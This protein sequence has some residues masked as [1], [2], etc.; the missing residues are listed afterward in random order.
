MS[1]LL[2]SGDYNNTKFEYVAPIK[3]IS[4]YEYMDSKDSKIIKKF[5]IYRTIRD[6][7]HYTGTF[8]WQLIA[9]VI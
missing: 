6:H 4:F 7:C 2:D 8:R 1:E 3:D 9:F 5:K